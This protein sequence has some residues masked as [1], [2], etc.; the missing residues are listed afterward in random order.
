MVVIK[1][2]KLTTRITKIIRRLAYQGRF[3]N[4]ELL[5]DIPLVLIYRM[6]I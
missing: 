3:E 4:P 2:T 5:Q 1:F 6:I